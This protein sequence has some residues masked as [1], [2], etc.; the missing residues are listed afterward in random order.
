MDRKS[1]FRSFGPLVRT[2]CRVFLVLPK[3]EK[4]LICGFQ[5][6]ATRC[7]EYARHVMVRAEQACGAIPHSG[8][9]NG[10]RVVC[11]KVAPTRAETRVLESVLD[12]NDEFGAKTAK[13]RTLNKGFGASSRTGLAGDCGVRLGCFRACFDSRP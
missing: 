3:P 7:A 5:R 2:S 12:E 11:Q 9:S 13:S 6:E 10:R 8:A 4:T 1:I